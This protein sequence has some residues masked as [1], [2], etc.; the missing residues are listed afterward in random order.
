MRPDPTWTDEEAR[1]IASLRRLAKTWPKSLVIMIGHSPG[2]A[3]TCVIHA[4]DSPEWIDGPGRPDV[5]SA[6]IY[7]IRI[8]SSS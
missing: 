1:A 2:D 6:N 4:A 3:S 5:S 8:D 7:G